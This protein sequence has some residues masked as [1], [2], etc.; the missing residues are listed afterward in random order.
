MPNANNIRLGTLYNII[1]KTKQHLDI[2]ISYL[3]NLMLEL[4]NQGF[5]H[6]LYHTFKNEK[7]FMASDRFDKNN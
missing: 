3:N 6:L 5:K 1:Y 2:R 7:P 4:N